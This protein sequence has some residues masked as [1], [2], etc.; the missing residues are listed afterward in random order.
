[1]EGGGSG[2]AF[3]TPSTLPTPDLVYADTKAHTTGTGGRAV[4]FLLDF[5]G[6]EEPYTKAH[7]ADT[8]GRDWSSNF[9]HLHSMLESQPTPR[10]RQRDDQ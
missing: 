8:G 4:E 10:T 2:Y 5:D 6:C 9:K 7:A 1:M 3:S